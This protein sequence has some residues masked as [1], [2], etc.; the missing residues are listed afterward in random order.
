[1]RETVLGKFFSVALLAAMCRTGR[2]DPAVVTNA[3]DWPKMMMEV[4]AKAAAGNSNDIHVA[5]N[6]VTTAYPD[7]CASFRNLAGLSLDE[8]MMGKS[9]ASVQTVVFRLIEKAA[10]LNEFRGQ[11]SAL[12]RK[13]VP[14][15]A[16][17]WMVLFEKAYRQL[18]CE[19]VR[20][21]PR[22]A[23]IRR[24]SYG[25]HGTNGTMFS[26]RTDR[27][28]AILVYDPSRP[29]LPAKVI[30]ETKD[31]FIW[32]IKP[33]YDGRKLLMSYKEENDLPFHIWEIGVEGSGLRQ[34][35]SGRYHDFNPVYYPDGRIVFCSS[36]VESYSLC[37]DFLASA[38]YIIN[39][40]GSNMR[41]FDFTTLCTSAPAV[42][43]DG[44][45]LCTRWEYNDK[46]IFSW[47]G[48][49][50]IHPDGRQL[51]LYYGNTITIPNS[52]YG[53]K[54]IPGTGEVMLTMAGHH[55]PPVADIAV[56]DRSKG[57]EN[58]AAMRKVTFE[59]TY[60]IT[61]GKT[62]RDTN[63]GPG[64]H[65]YPWSVTDPWPISDG[66]FL[67]AF[68]RPT[69]SP[70]GGRFGICLATY[71]GVRF[72]VYGRDDESFFSPVTLAERPLPNA[73]QTEVPV[74]AGEG[75]LYVQDVYQGLLEQGV[76]RGQ[77]KALRVIRQ[78][79][80]KWNTEGPRFHDHYPVIGFGSYYVK[81]N[82]GEVP[83]DDNGSAYFRVPSNCELYFIALDKDGKEVR[84]MGSVTQITTGEHVSCVGCHDDRMKAPPVSRQAYSRQSRPPDTLKP[85][86]WGA[87][88]FDYV[89]HVQ[90]VFDKY[91]VSCHS[92]RNP[93][94]KID[95]SG[96][97]SR[98]FNMSYDQ[99]VDRGMV[100]YYYIN[101]GPTGVFPAMSSGSYISKLTALI[102]GKHH[103]VDMDDESRRR[104]YTW[105][106][107]NI[108][109]YNT[110]DMSRPHT[111]GGRDPWNFVEDNKRVQPEPEPWLEKFKNA[112]DNHCSSCHGEVEVQGEKAWS[113]KQNMNF[114]INL[115]RPE[116][117][118][119]L[120]AHLSSVA[121]GMGIV[122]D[123][124][125]IKFE[126]K[127]TDDPV[128]LEMLEAINEGKAALE[129]RP[130]M[131]MPGAVAIPQ[132]RDFGKV[133]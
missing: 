103:K 61:K 23:F 117:S 50:T 53:G 85:P 59:T 86:P 26:H 128:Y 18:S 46:N 119:V 13:V 109:Y 89:K 62:W 126:I 81:E 82:L 125:N 97:K 108:Q 64:D 35:T 36:R 3:A 69:D 75:T 11:A 116:F 76:A 111:C 67:A 47:Q 133:F 107:S 87:G 58:P 16:P 95:L 41:R 104:V 7:L 43:P 121:G 77:V 25:L 15:T 102:E 4:R 122:A 1:M 29:D 19:R 98:F 79:P 27:G 9:T 10:T 63:W 112:Y 22:I 74:K 73:I 54:P 91:C 130:R 60:Q 84:R 80:K 96:D 78:T 56:V 106:D 66:L 114:W 88:P 101:P 24:K 34:L 132:E 42:L 93:K 37:Q 110:W 14:D 83:V 6:N 113:W 100:E 90:P 30:F 72:E 49:W 31:G 131:D 65:Y 124:K 120:N 118:R 57:I 40:D 12:A 2:T 123:K 92:G 45:I 105:I 8:W 20:A 5:A 44:T 70:E 33:S 71:D 38:L 68:G 129:K 21:C 28:S 32:D 55:L 52:R 94:G 39:G 17:E 127:D 48:M 51:K 115:T 99:L